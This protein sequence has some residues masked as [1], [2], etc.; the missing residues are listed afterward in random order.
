MTTNTSQRGMF[1]CRT[2]EKRQNPS[3]LFALL[4][5]GALWSPLKQEP[6]LFVT[7]RQRKN[8]GVGRG[9]WVTPGRSPGHWT[10]LQY[11]RNSS[12]PGQRGN[13]ATVATTKPQGSLHSLPLIPKGG[14]ELEKWAKSGVLGVVCDGKGKL[15]VQSSTCSSLW[16]IPDFSWMDVKSCGGESI[17][18]STGPF[19][20]FGV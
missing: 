17:C 1:L 11:V 3:L 7:P 14:W 4:A 15:G 13:R 10:L 8:L 6:E 18:G 9:S 16:F 19:L 20:G 5:F 2:V 12:K